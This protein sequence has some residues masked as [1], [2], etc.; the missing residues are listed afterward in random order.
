[1]AKKED[2]NIGKLLR[3]GRKTERRIGACGNPCGGTA[4]R[5]VYDRKGY[6]GFSCVC[7]AIEKRRNKQKSFDRGNFRII[8]EKKEEFCNERINGAD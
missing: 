7:H 3:A 8:T 4:R 1:M 2:E 6:A 5:A